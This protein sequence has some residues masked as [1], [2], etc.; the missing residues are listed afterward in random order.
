MV[1]PFILLRS[2][3]AKLAVVGAAG[4]L[5]A[6]VFFSVRGGDSST[7]TTTPGTGGGGA[8]QITA[9]AEPYSF[10]PLDTALG[11][12]GGTLQ[13][14]GVDG[15]LAPFVQRLAANLGVTSVKK[16]ATGFSGGGLTVKTDGT[17]EFKHPTATDPAP[18]CELGAPCVP[19]GTA[20]LPPSVALPAP[21]EV[22]PLAEK[23]FAGVTE[24]V[25]V[26]VS[27]VSRDQW[28]ASTKFSFQRGPMRMSETG[29]VVLTSGGTILRARGIVGKYGLGMEVKFEGAMS[30]FARIGTDGVLVQKGQLGGPKGGV[31]I[32]IV[33]VW[34][35]TAPSAAA[36]N[37]ESAV[38]AQVPAW[39][40]QDRNENVWVVVAQEGSSENSGVPTTPLQADRPG[41]PDTTTSD[42][43]SGSTTS[44]AGSAEP[45]STDTPLAPRP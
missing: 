2:P 23:V 40:F 14:V 21:N 22:A 37:G 6:A 33:K 7:A 42:S 31:T 45:G 19:Q 1:Q 34:L 38:V 30:A 29:E 20:T 24:N 5:A 10:A 32:E 4:L 39:A 36:K 43:S 3:R 13:V 41:T 44:T 25:I 28:R 8:P 17:W 18:G 26:S 27:G 9:M 12:P 35:T 16:T 15:D 11:Q